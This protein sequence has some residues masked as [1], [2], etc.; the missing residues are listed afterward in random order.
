MN[1]AIWTQQQLEDTATQLRKEG[2]FQTIAF[3]FLIGTFC[4]AIGFLIGV[5]I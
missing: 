5:T 2:N 3:A 1:K 4:L